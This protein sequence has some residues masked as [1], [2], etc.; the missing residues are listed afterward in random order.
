MSGASL[1]TVKRSQTGKK[2][3]N[4]PREGAKRGGVGGFSRKSRTRLMR[5]LAAVRRDKLPAFVTL[6][7]P[8]SYPTAQRAKRDLDTFI[9]RL[10]RRFPDVAG[11]WKLEPQ[12]RGAPHFH[13]LIWGTSYPELLAFVPD[14]W[15]QVVGS[16]DPNHL[17][18]HKGELGNKP[19]VQQ[20][21][22]QRGVFWYASKYMSK[23]VGQTFSSWGRWWGVFHRGKLPL[24]QVVNVEVTEQKAVE[25]IRY[26]RRFGHIRSRNYRTLTIICNPDMWLNR[27]L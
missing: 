21:E 1:L 26:M 27:L 4:Q 24:G 16:S 23:Q 12:R 7:F 13:L 17:K 5:T 15:Y 2:P 9:K 8:A 6:T 3:E 10:V 25:F 20:V 14:A 22:S 19:C 18:W 11:V